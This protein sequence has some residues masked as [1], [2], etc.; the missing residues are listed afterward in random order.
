MEE[1]S[2]DEISLIYNQVILL[3]KEIDIYDKY[4]NQLNKMQLHIDV[5]ISL[6]NKKERNKI[7]QFKGLSKFEKIIHFREEGKRIHGDK[8]DY[9][10]SEYIKFHTKISI[11]CRKCKHYFEQ[12]PANHLLQGSNCP[13]CVGHMQKTTEQF[14]IDSINLHGSKYNYSKTKYIKRHEMVTLICS[15]DN[16]EFRQSAGNHLHPYEG[17]EKC[18][19]RNKAEQKRFPMELFFEQAEA[20]H[21]NKFTYFKETYIDRNTIL[22]VKCNGCGE[23]YWPMAYRHLLH[24]CKLCY[25]I[26]R[27]ITLITSQKQYINEA[28]KIHGDAYDYK[29][30]VF[31]GNTKNIIVKCNNC[32]AIYNITAYKHL[33]QKNCAKCGKICGYSKVQIEW[34]NSI[35]RKFKI[36]IQSA[37]SNGGEHRVNT[38]C[39][40]NNEK[41][42]LPILQHYKRRK[43]SV[44]GFYKE[45]NI[46][47]EFAGCWWHYCSKC[48]DHSEILDIDKEFYKIRYLKTLEKQK[49]IEN[50]GYKYIIMWECDYNNDKERNYLKE[51]EKI[52][53]D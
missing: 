48:Y 2:Q 15:I 39:H 27:G 3:K 36:E 24:G 49:M 16:H 43:L 30:S 12:T 22:K 32:K 11:F 35:K 45:K 38:E 50:A 47:L 52:F 33:K 53:K 17:C 13:Y 1:I 46:V 37:I 26:Q 20:V 7:N 28:I 14:I 25:T 19:N 40:V 18:A 42:E 9:T 51:Y 6:K 44:D 8:Y 31:N 34:I 23:I 5:F 4:V 29:Y 10:L 41:I 21:G